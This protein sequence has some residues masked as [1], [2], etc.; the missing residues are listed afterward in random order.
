MPK[1]VFLVGCN[2][3]GTTMLNHFLG[4]HPDIDPLRRE[5]QDSP[6][7]P[8][9]SDYPDG[10]GFKLGRVW[11]EK[12]EIFRVPEVENVEQLKQSWLAMRVSKGGKY[13]MEKSPPNTVRS[14]WLQDNFP[15]SRFIGIVRNGY[16][17]S[18]GIKRRKR[19][20][21]NYERAARHW[22]KSN[23]I[24]LCDSKFLEYFRLVKYEN[25]VVNPSKELYCLESFLEI[26]HFDYDTI[27][28]KPFSIKG[29][30]HNPIQNMNGK[31][32][33]ALT[34]KQRKIIR[35]NA[36]EILDFFEYKAQQNQG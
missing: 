17:V 28:K 25:F 21:I 36:C 5:G 30:P 31:S 35:E 7:M 13:V 18:E 3:S 33:E 27:T 20:S 12:A 16:A 9:P 23:K 14:I 26:P 8:S 11:S 15:D 10:H 2:N 1:W 24:M 29:E 4:L 19:E 22:C 32:L 6:C 34:W